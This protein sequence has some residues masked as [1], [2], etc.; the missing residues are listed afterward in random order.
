[1]DRRVR[2]VISLLEANLCREVPLCELAR[3]VNLSSSRLCHLFTVEMG[4]PPARYLKTLRLQQARELLET[5][6]LNVKE[7]AN[8]VGINDESH[9]VRDFKKLHG[10]T[11]ARY[12]ARSL[13]AEVRPS[14]P[15]DMAAESAN[16]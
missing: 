9:F 12:R 13:A 14:E 3:S 11:P 2:K 10:L 1:M 7:V 5:S 8:K 16:R 15:L 6:F 4:V